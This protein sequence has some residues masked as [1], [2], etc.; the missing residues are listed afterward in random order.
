M[1]Y[2][3]RDPLRN[4]EAVVLKQLPGVAARVTVSHGGSQS[5]LPNIVQ[6]SD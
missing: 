2:G 6:S 5:A 4:V 3:K 1:Q